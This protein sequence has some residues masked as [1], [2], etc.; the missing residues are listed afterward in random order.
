MISNRYIQPFE[1]LQKGRNDED[2]L[3]RPLGP[4]KNTTSLNLQ[5]KSFKLPT[6]FGDG[7]DLLQRPN[8]RNEDGWD[9]T[10]IDF[11]EQENLND[12]L[13]GKKVRFDD[14]TLNKLF[15]VL[16]PDPRDALW[17]AEKNRRLNAG[18]SI[19]QI[20]AN[21]PFGRPQRTINKSENIG[22]MVSS[23]K[24]TLAI[25]DRKIQAGFDDSADGRN[26]IIKALKAQISVSKDLAN[27]TMNE[28]KKIG[29]LGNDYLPDDYETVF[30]NNRYFT[31]SEYK[32]NKGLINL[33]LLTRAFRIANNPKTEDEKKGRTLNTPVFNSVSNRFSSLENLPNLFNSIEQR[34][35]GNPDSITVLDVKTGSLTI[36]SKQEYDAT[37]L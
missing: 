22:Y 11:Q 10:I 15:N 23:V 24:E 36:I 28:F 25:I 30:D 9:R 8:F 1:E 31:A 6:R 34:R 16:I 2:N 12:K 14:N 20:N 32:S 33:W 18:E 13:Y 7:G 19:A 3:E 4:L 21:P 26:D 27:I 17:L 37:L 35:G 5:V 29:K